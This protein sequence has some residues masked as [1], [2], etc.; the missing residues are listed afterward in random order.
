MRDQG[1][2]IS[3]E[4]KENMFKPFF[5]TKDERSKKLNAQSHGIGLSFSKKIA[6]KLGGD[7]VLN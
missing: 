6:K 2:G 5:K 7:L 1:I 4:D 3:A